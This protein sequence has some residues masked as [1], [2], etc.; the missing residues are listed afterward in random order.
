MFAQYFNYI[1]VGNRQTEFVE[2]RRADK[3]SPFTL[4]TIE[5]WLESRVYSIQ[6]RNISINILRSH[7]WPGMCLCPLPRTVVPATPLDSQ[8]PI[9][10]SARVA[11]VAKGDDTCLSP[12]LLSLLLLGAWRLIEV[13]GALNEVTR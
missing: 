12:L 7:S 11:G 6:I 9:Q 3:L 13:E 2:N 10:S 1:K 8:C 5:T 4:D